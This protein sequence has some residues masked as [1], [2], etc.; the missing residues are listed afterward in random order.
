MGRQP[1]RR[2]ENN[3]E[4]QLEIR[5]LGMRHQPDFGCRNDAL[6]LLRGHCIGGIVQGCAG[7]DFDEREEI[8]SPGDDI[9]FAMRG[10]KAPRENAV[11]LCDQP[12]RSAAFGGEAGLKRRDA[13]GRRA[14]RIAA[15]FVSRHRRPLSPRDDSSSAR[16]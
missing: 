2:N 8:A 13:F 6:L 3:I 1:L 7:F 5:M 12:G 15:G 14:I 16:A 11:A 9:D 4:T 10:A